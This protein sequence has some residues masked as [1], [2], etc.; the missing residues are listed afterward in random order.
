MAVVAFFARGTAADDQISSIAQKSVAKVEVLP[1]SYFI[2]TTG[3]S[4]EK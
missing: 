2:G 1:G 3:V 4:E